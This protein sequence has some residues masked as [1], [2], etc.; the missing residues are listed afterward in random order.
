[1]DPPFLEKRGILKSKRVN[2][3]LLGFFVLPDRH[4]LGIN[5]FG[6]F[7]TFGCS[8]ILINFYREDFC[9]LDS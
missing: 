6:R 1:M 4:L 9:F 3:S 7:G 8:Q 2:L 5:F